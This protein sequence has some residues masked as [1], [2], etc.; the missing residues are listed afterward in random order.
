MCAVSKKECSCS[1]AV[2]LQSTFVSWS[3]KI[4]ENFVRIY[5]ASRVPCEKQYVEQWKV[6]GLRGQ[7]WTKTKYGSCICPAVRSNVNGQHNHVFVRNIGMQLAGFLYVAIQWGGWAKT[8][9]QGSLFSKKPTCNG[10]SGN[11]QDKRNTRTVH[12]L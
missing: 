2:I 1:L 4:A 12:R 11:Q 10:Y 8:R 5:P 7:C 6:I 3:E 9:S